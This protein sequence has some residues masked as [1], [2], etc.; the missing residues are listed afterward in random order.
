MNDTFVSFNK[1][2]IASFSPCEQGK[3][4]PSVF[5]MF[6]FKKRKKCCSRESVLRGDLM[7]V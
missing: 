6:F 4:S 5:A 7:T 3:M 1:S 2:E